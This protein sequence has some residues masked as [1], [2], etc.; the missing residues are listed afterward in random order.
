MPT[1]AFTQ[2]YD[3]VTEERIAPVKGKKLVLKGAVRDGD[4]VLYKFKARPRQNLTI[5]LVGRDADFSFS[6]IY[7][8]SVDPIAENTKSWSGRLPSGFTGN[9]EIA[10]HSNY[11]IA[12]YRL[13]V[14]LK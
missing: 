2:S 10:V 5:N 7:E 13:E 8:L 14:L 9:C 4:E 6:V 12:N 1:T 11:K 3:N